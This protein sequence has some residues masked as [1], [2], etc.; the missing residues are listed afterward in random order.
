MP[1]HPYRFTQ[2]SAAI[3]GTASAFCSEAEPHRAQW[4]DVRPR[5]GSLLTI[6]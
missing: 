4:C 5:M 3:L 2:P 6:C 1:C